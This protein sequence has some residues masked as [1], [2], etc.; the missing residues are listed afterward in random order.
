[1]SKLKSPA[2][3]LFTKT[4][5]TLPSRSGKL[6]W[7]FADIRSASSFRARSLKILCALGF[8]TTTQS[9][10]FLAPTQAQTSAGGQCATP[11][12]D[13]VDSGAISIVNTYYAGPT[14]ATAGSVSL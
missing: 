4:I 1:M 7:S 11:G 13:G 2:P 6:P 10:W 14:D 8:A 9:I 3:I 5:R 12:K